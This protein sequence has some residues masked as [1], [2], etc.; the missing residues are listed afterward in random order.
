MPRILL[1]ACH[2]PL[3]QGPLFSS[4]IG[5]SSGFKPA[6]PLLPHAVLIWPWNASKFTL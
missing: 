2:V 3:R 4:I 5:Q 1:G 6:V